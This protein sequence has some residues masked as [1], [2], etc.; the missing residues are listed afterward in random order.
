MKLDEL[1]KELDKVRYLMNPNRLLIVSLLYLFGPKKESEVVKALNMPWG[2]FSTHV[3]MLEREGY[4]KRKRIFTRKGYRT[5][6]SLT[7]EGKECYRRLVYLLREFL[8]QVGGHV[9]R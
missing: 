9:E 5:F 4:V 2:I 8:R 1:L 3:A 6:I 7:E